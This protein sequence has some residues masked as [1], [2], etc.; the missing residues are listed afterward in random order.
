MPYSSP[1]LVSSISVLKPRSAAQRRYM[2]SSISA[3]SCASVPPASAWIIT[4]ASPSS[5]SPLNSASSCSRSSSRPQ[6]HD[7]R[8]DLVGEAL[9][10]LEQL[11]RVVVLAR[12]AVVALEPPREP[13]VLGRDGRRMLR[14]V[15][16]AGLSELFLELGDPRRQRSGVKGNH[17]PSPAGPRSPSVGPRVRAPVDPP[18]HREWYRAART[19]SRPTPL[20]IRQVRCL[21]LQ[22]FQVSDTSCREWYEMHTPV[23]SLPGNPGGTLSHRVGR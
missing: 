7:R 6:R 22:G 19:T 1:G 20:H 9:V 8:R 13:S 15:P 11:A 23:S 4:T 16:E 5:Y 12:Q 3:Q 18:S 2:R 10:H 17:G 14:L 21:T